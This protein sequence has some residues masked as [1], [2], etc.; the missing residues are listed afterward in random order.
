MS[1]IKLA[2]DT[3]IGTPAGGNIEYDGQFFGT[4]S[5]NS[6]AQMQ[7]LFLSTAQASTSGTAIDF[8]DIPS[9]VKR[10]TVMFRGVSSSSTGLLQIRLGTGSSPTY[11]AT[12]YNGLASATGG[13]QQ[14]YSTGFIIQAESGASYLLNGIAIL[15]NIS[16]ND[17]A[18]SCNL[19][20]QA[21]GQG[22]VYH[23][24]GSVRLSNALTAVRVSPTSGNFD[25]GSIN[26]LYEG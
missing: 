11:L 1:A 26:I 22:G 17:W 21:T 25:A 3:L 12:G 20:P 4:D 14:A 24:A 13:G 7:R 2:P 9:W 8:T 10:I 18:I 19:A 16:D 23:S 15:T 6:R 5:N